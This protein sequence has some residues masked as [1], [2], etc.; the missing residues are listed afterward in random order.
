MKAGATAIILL[1]FSHW[2]GTLAAGEIIDRVAAVV[3]REIITASEVEERL[4]LE[5]LF[6]GH[7]VDLSKQK[8]R[9]ALERLIDVRLVAGEIVAKNFPSVTSQNV[10]E[11]LAALELRMKQRGTV[12]K[13]ELKYHVLERIDVEQFLA[14]QVN[15]ERFVAFRFKTGIQVSPEAVQAHYNESFVTE[16]RRLQVKLPPLAEVYDEI[17]ALV[18]DQRADLMLE[19]WL[20]ETRARIRVVI[21]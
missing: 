21:K 3:G 8:R 2:Q 19:V 6:N 14:R 4:R 10:T 12:L 1:V 9:D 13:Q 16:I 11:E 15:F 7:P 17:V 5:A 20:K 18:V